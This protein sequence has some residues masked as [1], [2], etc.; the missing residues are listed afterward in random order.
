MANNMKMKLLI[1]SI[2]LLMIISACHFEKNS[3][4]E[5][6]NRE[7]N[8]IVDEFL[9]F[10]FS[11]ANL[12]QIETKKVYNSFNTNINDSS[13]DVPSPELVIF[14]KE[15]FKLLTK[16]NLIDITD[17]NYMYGSI[18]STVT[19]NIDSTK[20]TKSVLAREKIELLMRKNGLDTTFHYFY[21]K[22]GSSCFIKVSTPIFNKE[23]TKALIAVDYYCGPLN[24][25]GYNILLENI[26]G[27]WSII[28]EYS[29][30]V[31]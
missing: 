18:D 8:E 5:R 21:K 16:R 20:I 2:G 14:H 31:S 15:L 29:K 1:Y 10:R 22:Y 9:R 12:V 24:G 11:D 3:R 27:K 25:A 13:V 17:A 4:I 30:W 23:F 28:F 19:I 26:R 7:L 6:T